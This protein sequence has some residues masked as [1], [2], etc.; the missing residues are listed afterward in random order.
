MK[1]SLLEINIELKIIIRKESIGGRVRAVDG[2]ES[3]VRSRQ[4]I[5]ST[6]NAIGG[7]T[8]ERTNSNQIVSE[9]VRILEILK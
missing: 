8:S 7:E 2:E 9:E 1:Y 5:P 4:R 6:V 3:A